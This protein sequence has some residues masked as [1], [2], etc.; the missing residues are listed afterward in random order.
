M[1]ADHHRRRPGRYIRAARNTAAS[2][3]P[4]A[5]ATGMSRP[6]F[7]GGAERAREVLGG[8]TLPPAAGLGRRATGMP[9][10]SVPI[11]IRLGSRVTTSD[12]SGHPAVLAATFGSSVTRRC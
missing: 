4:T 12:S 5:I 10:G 6:D 11:V 8:G 7:G 3:N 9:D 2:I 1:D